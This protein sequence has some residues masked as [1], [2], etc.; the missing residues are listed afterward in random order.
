MKNT[1][2]MSKQGIVWEFNGSTATMLE[3]TK[4]LKEFDTSWMNDGTNLENIKVEDLI[5]DKYLDKALE[6]YELFEELTLVGDYKKAEDRSKEDVEK[7]Q[8]AIQL[9]KKLQTNTDPALAYGF[10]LYDESSITK[11]YWTKRVGD[12]KDPHTKQPWFKKNKKAEWLYE[13]YLFLTGQNPKFKG[14]QLYYYK[15]T[16]STGLF[17]I[18]N[19]FKMH[20]NMYALSELN[21]YIFKRNANEYKSLGDSKNDFEITTDYSEDDIAD[22]LNVE[23]FIRYFAKKGP[24]KANSGS[25]LEGLT[26]KKIL[27][28]IIKNKDER[29][30]KLS[31]V[32][33]LSGQSVL[34]KVTDE[35]KKDMKKFDVD[36]NSFAKYISK[37]ETV[38]LDI[39]NGKNTTFSDIEE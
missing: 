9:L 22:F 36:Q 6:Y 13:I 35:L 14:N 32:L 23:D 7:D 37:Y 28:E 3:S 34:Y 20:W 24:V 8:R 38:A 31:K 18:M 17:N 4:I 16:Q 11:A 2:K 26:W 33:G 39:L 10:M 30:V 25:S 27:E 12:R 19:N 29:A 1:S 21:K 15:F 5:E